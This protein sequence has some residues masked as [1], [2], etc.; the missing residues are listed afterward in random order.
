MQQ[1]SSGHNLIFNGSACKKQD[2]YQ[3]K[4]KTKYRFNSC[5]SSLLNVKLIVMPCLCSILAV[6]RIRSVSSKHVARTVDAMVCQKKSATCVPKTSLVSTSSA[7]ALVRTN[8]SLV[9]DFKPF[10]KY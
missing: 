6:L 7:H 2:L 4:T 8:N 3:R 1:V 9:R 10:Q 5:C